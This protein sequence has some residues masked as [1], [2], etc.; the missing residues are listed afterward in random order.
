MRK[1]EQIRYIHK[2]LWVKED[3]DNPDMEEIDDG[4]FDTC[5]ANTIT[6]FS[7]LDIEP[8]LKA[9]IIET[10]SGLRLRGSSLPHKDVRSAILGLMND[11]ERGE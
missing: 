5:L 10:L 2:I 7:G 6:R 11:I 9:K 1:D 8:K 4:V 3:V